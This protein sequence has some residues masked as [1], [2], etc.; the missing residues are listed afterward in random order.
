MG[1]IAGLGLI[2]VCIMGILGIIIILLGLMKSFKHGTV[3]GQ[4]IAV[5]QLHFLRVT[6]EE[7]MP[8]DATINIKINGLFDYKHEL[9]KWIKKF[10]T[11][12]SIELCEP[13]KFVIQG[14][15]LSVTIT[16]VIIN[17]ETVFV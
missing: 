15:R 12:I 1:L 7:L 10:G 14:K 16:T 5:P 8:F 3:K 6:P 13:S 4:V 2:A 11:P 9:E 17:S